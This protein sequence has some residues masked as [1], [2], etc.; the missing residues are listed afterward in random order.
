MTT[1][2]TGNVITGMFT[3]I[4][5]LLTNYTSEGYQA[6]SSTL[7]IPLGAAISLY[8]V[9]MGFAIS[10][11]FVEMKMKELVVA[12]LKIAVVYTAAMNW[13]FVNTYFIALINSVVTDV[14]NVMVSVGG[15]D[16]TRS[17]D[18]VSDGLQTL[19]N[20]V[21][22]LAQAYSKKGGVTDWMPCIES[23][24]IEF[25]G[26][27]VVTLAS[28]EILIALTFMDILF[29]MTPLMVIFYFFTPTKSMFEHWLNL[30]F[31]N[32]MAII[33]VSSVAG[34]VLVM[35]SWVFPELMPNSK[36]LTFM[37]SGAA[38]V[39]S[40]VSILLLFKAAGVGRALA[41]GTSSASG[42]AAMV[43]L[44]GMAFAVKK[45]KDLYPRKNGN[46]NNNNNEQKGGKGGQIA[47]LARA[48]LR[49]KQQDDQY[50]GKGK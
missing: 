15:S 7:A 46:K 49:N 1:M 50:N 9:L 3:Q 22:E 19:L 20:R 38:A 34:L 10:Q 28:A 25:L 17:N 4:Q 26:L 30:I 31:G 47:R 32:G 37:A 27:I 6:L 23:L 21:M 45:I 43:V 42:L 13:D 11:G 33:L 18:G 24:V 40:F 16:I 44:G 29:A 2:T 14:S 12:S 41:G 5:S 36:D 35:M 8:I 39:I 48:R